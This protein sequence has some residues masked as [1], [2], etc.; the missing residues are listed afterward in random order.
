[1][2]FTHRNNIFPED[3]IQINTMSQKL[4]TRLF[5]LFNRFVDMLDPMEYK[6]VIPY[7]GD[8]L[9]FWTGDRYE[10]AKQVNLYFLSG[11]GEFEWH[12]PYTVLEYFFQF[13]RNCCEYTCCAS[14]T[15]ET[16]SKYSQLLETLPLAVNSILQEERSGYRLVNWLFTPITDDIEVSEIESG[17]TGGI[18]S[19]KIHLKKALERYSD[20]E[21]P[22]YENSIKESICAVESICCYITGA[23]GAQATLGKVIKMLKD[24][25]IHIHKSLENA[26]NALYGYTSDENGIR[27]GG[28]D[29]QH[30]P[31]EDARFM[32]VICSAFVNYLEE[33][34]NNQ[35]LKHLGDDNTP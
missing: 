13:L 12:S 6:E 28:I 15:A 26:F 22:D 19:A 2:D 33:K 3:P 4:R 31:A 21:K 23:R 34:V 18:S 24:G 32:L 1:M 29:F 35:K 5:N 10:C 7:I 20:R 17:V 27:H 11:T 25:G 9:G 30:A 14:D 8:K 16:V